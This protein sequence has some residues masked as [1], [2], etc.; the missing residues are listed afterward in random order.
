MT[1]LLSRPLKLANV[2]KKI[3]GQFPVLIEAEPLSPEP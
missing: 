3:V 2:K 1:D